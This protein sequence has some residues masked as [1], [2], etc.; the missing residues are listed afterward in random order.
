M[1]NRYVI[2]PI[3]MLAVLAA[4]SVPVLAACGDVVT[5]KTG[6]VTNGKVIMQ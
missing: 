3:V 1:K 2:A 6:T 4:S 5:V